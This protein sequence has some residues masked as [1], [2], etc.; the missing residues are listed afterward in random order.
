MTVYDMS[1][2][3]SRFH[4]RGQLVFDS[5]HR[6]GA[7]Q[8][9]AADAPNLPILRT[10]DGRPYIPGSSFKGAWRA[11]TESILRTLQAQP[12]FASNLTCE[13]LAEEDR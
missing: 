1:A 6:I 2:F 5:A 3:S 8:S 7:E 10:V 9:L 13:P 11:Y 12:G 4:Y